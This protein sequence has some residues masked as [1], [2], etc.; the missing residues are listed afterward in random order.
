MEGTVSYTAQNRII[1]GDNSTTGSIWHVST[2]EGVE[3]SG[4]QE[5]EKKKTFTAFFIICYFTAI[6]T[7]L[8]KNSQNNRTLAWNELQEKLG[9]RLLT[10][11][12]THQV[13]LETRNK[14]VALFSSDQQNFIGLHKY[15]ANMEKLN[16]GV[17]HFCI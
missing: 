3:G 11:P 4:T 12:N 14:L 13:R 5:M 16:C 9:S 1:Q 17:H 7:A 8:R 2:Y 6:T 15:R 10:R